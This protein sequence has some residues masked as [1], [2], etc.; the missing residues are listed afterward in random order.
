MGG[1]RAQT[2]TSAD[3]AAHGKEIWQDGHNSIWE[4]SCA[5]PG[6]RD[7]AS[8]AVEARRDGHVA[9]T[10]NCYN[11]GNF[12][13]VIWN[14]KL[15]LRDPD[16]IVLGGSGASVICSDVIS[17]IFAPA[18]K[19][20]L[21]H[22]CE[23]ESVPILPV[24]DVPEFD[25]SLDIAGFNGAD[26]TATNVGAVAVAANRDDFRA[27]L[28]SMIAS[29]LTPDEFARTR[30]AIETDLSQWATALHEKTELAGTFDTVQVLL[31]LMLSGRADQGRAALFE[32]TQHGALPTFKAEAFWDDLCLAVISHALWRRFDLGRLPHAD[33]IEASAKHG[34]MGREGRDYL[35]TS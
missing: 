10:T 17:I 8:V 18:P 34:K 33:L 9:R 22:F 15:G 24:R 12:V 23:A 21:L 16:A 1:A 28:Q 4:V 30:E 25:A 20:R 2:H 26:V 7:D 13:S 29:P 31:D 6:D 35:P 14:D 27:D 11:S 32:A 3:V 19:L 5:R